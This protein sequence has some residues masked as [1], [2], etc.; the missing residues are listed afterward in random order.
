MFDLPISARIREFREVA[1]AA[2]HRDA[3][4][5]FFS[6]IMGV[7]GSKAFTAPE[8]RTMFDE[9]SRRTIDQI[10]QTEI[11]YLITPR[12]NLDR[13]PPE[14]NAVKKALLKTHLLCR[15]LER[16]LPVAQL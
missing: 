2:G 8:I 15:A 5:Y 10:T 7:N 4:A 3:Q 16:Y 11:F 12:Q 6:E 13:L 14:E 9:M 1:H